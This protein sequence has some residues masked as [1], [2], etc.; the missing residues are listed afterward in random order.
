[1]EKLTLVLGA[2]VLGIGG[3]AFL[4]VVMAF[5]IK[6]CW[7]ATMPGLFHLAEIGV[8]QAWCLTFMGSSF[9]K[10]HVNLKCKHD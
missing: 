5:P 7:N 4:S 1:M 3:V 2:W 9:F 10:A 8:V 6:W